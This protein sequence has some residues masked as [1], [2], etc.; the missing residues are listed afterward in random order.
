MNSLNTYRKYLN[1][2]KFVDMFLLL[3]VFVILT[4]IFGA[5]YYY[6]ES[7]VLLFLVCL[8]IYCIC[9]YLGKLFEVKLLLPSIMFFIVTALLFT[10]LL[11]SDE[12]RYMENSFS[13]YVPLV[14]VLVGI[15]AL[16]FGLY[17]YETPVALYLKIK[18]SLSGLKYG[19]KIKRINDEK[20]E[21]NT[22]TLYA[23]NL[24][25]EREKLLKQLNEDYRE[26][27]FILD[28]LFKKS[29]EKQKNQQDILDD[30]ES[31]LEKINTKL[32]GKISGAQEYELNNQKKELKEKI[33]A[34]KEVLVEVNDEVTKNKNSLA[35]LANIF[36]KETYYIENAYNMRYKSYVERIQDKLLKTN[37]KLKVV[38]FE[39]LSIKEGE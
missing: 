29:V 27:Y 15:I 35:E 1:F 6:T 17:K 20:I 9:V 14:I 33:V 18:D 5:V 10:F 2:N 13:D 11:L 30:M 8:V 3:V 7:Y 31:N 26:E 21:F 37:Y 24:F 4:L 12:T 16:I 28:N 22:N 25:F 34:Q 32:K 36:E 39:L 19:S 38:P 23:N